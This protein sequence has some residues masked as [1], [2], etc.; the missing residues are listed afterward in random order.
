MTGYTSDKRALLREAVG[1]IGRSLTRSSLVRVK[2]EPK[3]SSEFV[4]AVSEEAVT[5]ALEAWRERTS[6]LPGELFSDP[7]WGMLLEL[8]EAEVQERRVSSSRLCKVS[9][10][11]DSTAARWLKALERHGLAVRWADRKCPDKEFVE[12]SRKGSSALRRYFHDVVQS[13]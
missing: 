12:L 11:S 4:L 9:G 6:Y 1:R 8:L 13:H 5:D 7:A 3:A 10:V 2:Q